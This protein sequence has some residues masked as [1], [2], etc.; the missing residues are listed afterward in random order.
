M[1]AHANL[2]KKTFTNRAKSVDPLLVSRQVSKVPLWSLLAAGVELAC[3]P[4]VSSFLRGVWRFDVPPLL[5]F[6]RQSGLFG[7]TGSTS[8]I[9]SGGCDLIPE[10]APCSPLIGP[11]S[12]ALSPAV[13]GPM[14]APRPSTLGV[15]AA[16]ARRCDW[17]R[18]CHSFT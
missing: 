11:D 17:L 6:S 8:S 13:S 5:L 15:T 7:P 2:N 10:P 16:T 1:F 14:D 4:T 18:R 3:P 9:S 12:A